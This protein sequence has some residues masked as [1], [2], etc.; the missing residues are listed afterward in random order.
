MQA[1]KQRKQ[2]HH[3]TRKTT[4]AR[5]AMRPICNNANALKPIKTMQDTKMQTAN[6]ASNTSFASNANS[7]ASIDI[8]KH[9]QAM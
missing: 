5:K 3:E 2:L 1:P 8:V 7:N 4:H 6:N 9:R